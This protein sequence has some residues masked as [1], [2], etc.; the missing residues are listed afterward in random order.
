MSLA[1]ELTVSIPLI[2]NLWNGAI[3]RASVEV[4][5]SDKN[6]NAR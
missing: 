2:E 5:T 6:F 4:W 1:L 3:D